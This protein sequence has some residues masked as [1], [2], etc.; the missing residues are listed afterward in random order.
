[1]SRYI[2][3]DKLCNDI[4]Q[5]PRGQSQEY[6]KGFWDCIF[7]FSELL[8]KHINNTTADVVEVVRCKD[9]KHWETI[10]TLYGEDNVCKRQGC[11]NVAKAP[12]DY[13][14]LGERS[15]E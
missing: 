2:D 4:P 15:E 14:S 10:K 13:C 7:R 3:A 11:M 6:D 8:R 1:M 9:C 5:C 12:N